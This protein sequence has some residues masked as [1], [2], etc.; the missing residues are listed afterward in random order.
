MTVAVTLRPL[1]ESDLTLV[2]RWLHEPHLAR[3]WLTS[4]TVE[5][6]LNDI[7]GYLA[8]EPF[9]VL[10]VELDGAPV[11]W[12]QWYRWWD[13]PDEAEEL[14]VGP[15]D[16]GIDYGIGDPAAVALGVGTAAIAALVAHI[17]RSVPDVAI[18]VE[19]DAENIASRRVLEK[20]GFTLVDLRSL[21]FET[22]ERNAI[23]R[24]AP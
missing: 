22:E 9:E 8:G 17:Q 15:D 16:V 13:D 1:V 20:N 7:R 2:E 3:W 14:G 10:M 12:C 18:V 21:S 4:N 24:L 5:D 23:Y 19:P 6:E 11:G